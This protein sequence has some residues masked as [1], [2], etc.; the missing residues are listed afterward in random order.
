M[1]TPTPPDRNESKR[2]DRFQNVTQPK[3]GRQGI[4]PRSTI[5]TITSSKVT[6]AL[7]RR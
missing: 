4:A 1:T 6:G 5:S 3:L 2:F 7:E